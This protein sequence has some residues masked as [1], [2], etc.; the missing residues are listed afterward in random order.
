M[1]SYTSKHLYKKLNDL[2]I[3]C[4]F[5]ISRFIKGDCTYRASALTFTT[6]LAIVP[7]MSVGFSILSTFPVFEDLR[8]P[9][10]DF[11]FENFVPSTGKVLQE[12]L[13]SFTKQVAKLS[14]VGVIFLF[15]TALLVMRTIEASMNHIFR[16]H[17]QRRGV[18]AFLLYW[19]IL[20]LAP[21]LLGL[22]LAASSYFF[23]LPFVK[24]HHAPTIL[25]IVSPALISLIGFT[26]LYIVVPNTKVPI[27]HGLV[28]ALVATFLFETAKKGFAYYLSQFNTYELLYGAFATIPIFFVWVYW[29]WLITLFGAEITY[30]LSVHYER[31]KGLSL[32]GLS[33]C[34][35]WLHTLWKNQKSGQPTSAE[36][37]INST[38]KPYAVDIDHVLSSLLQVGLI[39]KTEDGKYTIGRALN[40][41]SIYELK[42]MLPFGLPHPLELPDI[43]EPLWQQWQELIEHVDMMLKKELNITMDDFFSSKSIKKI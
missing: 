28:G 40:R 9:L 4:M 21:I 12:Y 33:H 1:A 32:D 41:I 10:Q 27:T 15:I 20:S 16:V 31:R 25:L 11:I 24:G 34:F 42:M 3:F 17:S 26:F 8:A 13:Q 22:S 7:L 35:W 14:I 5:V 30:A 2:K 39:Q 19:A 43:N 29:T 38:E 37:L 36:A 6:L 23:S 18:S